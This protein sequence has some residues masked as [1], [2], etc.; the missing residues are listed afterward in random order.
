MTGTTTPE[1]LTC[2]GIGIGSF[3]LPLPV[4]FA[5]ANREQLLPDRA[6][7]ALAQGRVVV[8]ATADRGRELLV[9]LLLAI[10]RHLE[11]KGSVR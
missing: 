8:L 6:H 7:Q 10:V 9:T 1:L 11:P 3:V 4:F 2:L 5:L